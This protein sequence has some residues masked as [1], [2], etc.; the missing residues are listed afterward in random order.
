METPF[1]VEDLRASR[2]S[3]IERF[4]LGQP[5]PL[6]LS[7]VLFYFVLFCFV[8]FFFYFILV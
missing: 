6:S 4:G 8:L 2:I 3:A 5:E 1:G 7:V